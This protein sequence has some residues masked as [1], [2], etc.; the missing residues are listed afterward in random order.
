MA[1]A[2]TQPKY[3]IKGQPLIA[4]PE[5]FQLRT[6]ELGR[7]AVRLMNERYAGNNNVVLDISN[8]REGQPIGY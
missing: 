4:V 7:D 3:E 6:D 1:Q 8:L 5:I 2:Q